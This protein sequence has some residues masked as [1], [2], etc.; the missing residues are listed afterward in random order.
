[1]KSF[2]PVF[3][4]SLFNILENNFVINRE[5]FNIQKGQFQSKVGTN[6]DL[7]LALPEQ[8]LSNDQKAERKMPALKA[9]IS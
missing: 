8:P 5:D 3:L 2:I 4:L 9:G 7:T 6:I 1:L